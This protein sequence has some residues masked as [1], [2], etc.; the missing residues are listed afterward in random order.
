MTT[1]AKA[2]DEALWTRR[3]QQMWLVG[4]TGI[5]AGMISRY[6]NGKSEPSTTHFIRLCAALPELKKWF[7]NEVKAAA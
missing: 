4:E 3:K 1:L 5:S 2:I 7:A 6:R